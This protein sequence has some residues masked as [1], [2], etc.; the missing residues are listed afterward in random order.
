MECRKATTDDY[1]RIV[2]SIQNKHI[3]F[4]TPSHVKEDIALDRQYVIEEQGKIIA[5]L[6]AVYDNDYHYTALKRMCVPNRKNHGKHL[7][8]ILTKYV[9]E[10]I[11]GKVGCTPWVDNTATR[12]ILESLGFSLEYIFND[13]WCFYAKG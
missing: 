1:I 3:S 11:E 2:R 5:I 4:L 9:S 6:S 13:V 7:A 8:T 10:Q 12:H